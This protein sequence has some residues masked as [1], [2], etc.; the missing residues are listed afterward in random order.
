MDFQIIDT[1]IQL[2]IDSIHQGYT[3]ERFFKAYH[4][5]KKHIHELRMGHLV[6]LNGHAV[7]QHF[8]LSLKEGDVLSFPFFIPESIDFIPDK[9]YLDIVYEDPFILVINKSTPLLIHPSDKEG[10]NTLV[11]HVAYYYKQT[12]QQCRVRY[13]HRLDEET[14]GLIVFAKTPFVHRYYDALLA[15]QSIKRVYL[16]VVDGLFIQK[17]GTIESYLAKDRHHSIKRR[18]SKQG[19]YAKTIYQVIKENKHSKRSLV[20]CELVTG[21]THQIRVHLSSNGHPI[22]GD[23][24]YNNKIEAKMK[25]QA[26]HAYSLI[27]PKLFKNTQ[28]ELVAR[29]P[30]DISRL[31]DSI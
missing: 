13:I 20:H 1:H 3:I 5:S 11:N 21:R 28:L 6:Y 18:V 22:V 16:A 15:T 8:T 31:V 10:R 23:A 9:G 19:E 26:L 2:T 12:N 7:Y 25:R 17:K 24:L 4:L 14:S 27:L 29:L 30:N